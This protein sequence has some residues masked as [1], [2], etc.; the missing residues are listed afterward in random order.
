MI[1]RGVTGRRQIR[2]ELTSQKIVFP[3]RD[4]LPAGLAS[5]AGAPVRTGG[6]ARAY[7]ELIGGHV[8]SATGG[9]TYSQIADQYR[10]GGQADPGLARL[11]ETAF[12]GQTLRGSLLGAYQA[13][14]ITRLVIGLGVLFTAVGIALLALAAAGR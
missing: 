6:Q 5:H 1:G 7:A 10:S 12:M 3:A 9:R 2:A 13:W 11:R 8:E 14:E 4:E